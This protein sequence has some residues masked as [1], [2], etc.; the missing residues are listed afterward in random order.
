L[1]FYRHYQQFWGFRSTVLWAKEK[2]LNVSQTW[3]KKELY[4]IFTTF[5]LNSRASRWIKELELELEFYVA[6]KPNIVHN[7]LSGFFNTE[8]MW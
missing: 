5:S 8:I 7:M 2:G 6:H 1:T 4:I 3:Y